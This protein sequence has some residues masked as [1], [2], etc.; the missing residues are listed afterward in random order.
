MKIP[1]PKASIII[2]ARDSLANL[3]KTIE[4]VLSADKGKEVEII[5]INDDQ[6]AAIAELAQK[7]PVNLVPGNSGGA[8]AARNLGIKKAR[9]SLLLFL[10]ADC[11]ASPDWI[12]THLKAHE[13]WD[14]P[15][16]VGGAIALETGASFWARCDH[17]CC[18]Y[19]VNPGQPPAWVPNHPAAN[20]SMS[21]ATFEAVGWFKEDLPGRGVHE[22]TEWQVRLKAVDGRIRFEPKALVSHTDRNDFRSFLRHNF[23]WGYNSLKV[24]GGNAVSRFPRLYRKPRML[25]LGFFPFAAAF[26]AYT[27]I[28]WAKAGK[29][30]PLALSPIVFLGHLAYAIG[31]VAGGIQ[32]QIYEKG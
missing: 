15:L 14:F 29:A 22:E 17:Y 1:A 16:V 2:P 7:Y 19:N 25:I 18:W 10:D 9:G 6:N 5:I 27:I 11:R 21:R 8:A 28:L 12:T 24:K 4:S 32:A 26:T 31:M 23:R 13:A 3:G 30:E 20:M